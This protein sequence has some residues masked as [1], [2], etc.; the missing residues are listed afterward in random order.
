MVI[1]V[2]AP[3]VAVQLHPVAAVTVIVPDPADDGRFAEDG[4]IVGKHVAAAWFTVRVLP[5]IETVPVRAVATVFAETVY[6]SVPLPVPV[7][8]AVTVIH[9]LLLVAVQPQPDA[10]PTVT[11]PDVPAGVIETTAGVT[12][13][14]QLTPACVTVKVFP[15]IVSVPVREVVPALAATL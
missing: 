8:P 3:L 13:E 15:P 5:P 2:A 7:A 9:A 6:E 10:A 14:T 1:H 12:A 11:M 4:D